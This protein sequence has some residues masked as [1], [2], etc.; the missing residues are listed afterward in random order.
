MALKL[1]LISIIVTVTAAISN[2]QVINCPSGFN[3]TTGVCGVA[4]TIQ[5]TGGFP[6]VI[7]GTNVSGGAHLS[8]SSIILQPSG[9]IGDHAPNNVN[10]VS[11]PVNV[12]AFS[13][14]FTFQLNTWNLAFI[15]QNVTQNGGAGPAPGYSLSQ[16]FNGGAGCEGGIYQ[17]F[18]G[19]GNPPPNNIFALNIDSGNL[20]SNTETPY[21]NNAQ[22]YQ[23]MQT[24]CIPGDDSPWFYFSNKVSTSPV[25]LSDISGTVCSPVLNSSCVPAGG[26]SSPDIFS[27]S[28][29]YTGSTVTLNL[30]DVTA[31]GTCSP[32]TSGTCFSNSWPNVLIPTLVNGTTATVGFG[33]SANGSPP[34]NLVVDS[35][36]YT[37]LSAAA[38]PTF[39]PIAGTYGS[40]QTVTISVSSPGSVICWNTT[41]APATNG[42][43]GCSNGT[44]FTG[45]I[46]V[47]KGQTLYAVAGSGTSSYGD[48]AV[49]SAAYNITGFASAPIFNQPA[50]TWQGNQTVQL[51]AAQGGVICFST[52]TT[53]A[54]NGSTGCS[55]G[56]LY[57]TP[58]TVSSNETINAI[59]G[60][61]GFA[62]SPVSSAAYIIS[63][64]AVVNGFT[65]SFPANSPTFSPVAG[66]YSGMQSVT[67]SSTTPSATI[68]YVLSATVPV[69][70]PLPNGL[71]SNGTTAGCAVGTLY[72]GPISVLSSES[73]YATAATTVGPTTPGTGPPSSVSRAA[74]TITGAGTTTSSAHGVSAVGVKIQ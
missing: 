8:G 62:D 55:T 5:G 28:I 64:F 3:N 32:V 19:S 27:A 72:S 57:S 40:T 41:G 42:I 74:F 66:S 69:F 63:P 43:G 13:T 15:L 21:F 46:S 52:S 45:P 37:V 18:G 67:L 59:A 61:T 35:F 9:S 38:T 14:T 36:V 56:T 7:F 60:G 39:S 65:G 31:G 44:L 1:W 34:N 11:A 6:L 17:A 30:F 70:F 16:S 58:L 54:T 23:S 26:S 22:I 10:F 50:G 33:G 29:F 2:A 68:C 53:P 20:L 25:V 4:P 24:P 73:I 71:G 12:Q 49:G 47:A 48:S 51:T